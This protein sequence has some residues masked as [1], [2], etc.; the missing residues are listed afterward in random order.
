MELQK[1]SVYFNNVLSLFDG[2]S[3]G[4]IAL[5]RAG[6]GYGNYYASEIDK[7]AMKVT[8]E[9]Y[10]QTVQIGDVT[11]VC[12]KDLPKIDLLIGG[13]PCQSFSRAGDGSGFDGKSGLFWEYA[14]II[15]EVEPKHFLFE[16]VLMKKEWESVITKELGVEPIVIDSNLLSGQNRKRLYWTNI[17]NVEIPKDLGITFYN[18]VERQ[19]DDKY[20]LS[21]KAIEYMNRRTRLGKNHWEI[22]PPAPT[23]NHK[24][25]T[26]VANYSAGIPYNVI[27]EP[28]S[29]RVRRL[30]PNECEKLQTIPVDYTK[31][32]SD[33]QRYK[34]IGN[35]WT[36]D[37]IAHIFSSLKNIP[38]QV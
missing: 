31:I 9:N 38:Y 20:Y 18:I 13:S 36:V 27:I 8:Q 12:G 21:D 28:L 7:W 17:K 34:C 2:M 1:N 24:S 19:V 16:N 23:K 22:H 14:R 15:K 33:T 26:I 4:Q 5:N 35:G 32:L 37:V 3:C 30:T 10:P 29:D 25:N 11:K 6:I